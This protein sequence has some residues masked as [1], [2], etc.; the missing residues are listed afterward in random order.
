MDRIIIEGGGA[1]AGEIEIS[2]AKNACLALMPAALLTTESLTLTNVPFLSDINTM[3]ELLV[4]LGCEISSL[5]NKRTTKISSINISNHI[6]DYNIVRKMRASILVLGPLLA[7]EKRAVVSLPGGCAIGARPVDIHLKALEAMGAKLELKDGYIFAEAKM[8]LQAVDHTFPMV[9]VGATANIIMAATLANGTTKLQNCALEPEIKDL[10]QCLISMGAKIQGEG[11]P[12][13]SIKGVNDLAG[14]THS[15][16]IDRI[17]LGTYM[18]A[19][20]IAGGEVFLRGGVFT[21][22][23]SFAKALVATGAIVSEVDGGLVVKGSKNGIDPVDISTAPYPGFPTDLQAQMM[24]LLT[25]SKGTSK[26]EEN[27]F[28]NRF[29]H[30]PELNRMGAKILVEGGTAIV[31]G[32]E[33]LKGAPVMA[34][35]LRASV[36]LI[37]A[38]LAAEGETSISRVYHLDRGYE[39]VCAKLSSCGVKIKRLSS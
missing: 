37:L 35:D 18:L 1:L 20:A 27:I 15:V 29:M 22:V 19:P 21:L 11:T 31:K 12:S 3:K 25:L 28:E 8:G 39:N 4:S 6:A 30:A 16:I 33:T 34:T 36:S 14:T 5:D 10:C 24:A 2:G 13:I 17:E 32:V 7:R 9:S 38:A 26:L 23:E